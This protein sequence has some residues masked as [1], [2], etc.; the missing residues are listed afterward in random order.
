MIIYILR[1]A[2]CLA[3]LLAVYH[4]LL[5]KKKMHTF[6]RFYLLLSLAAGLILPVLTINISTRTLND[7]PLL[8]K[9]MAVQQTPLLVQPEIPAN[10][11]VEHD[12]L[13]YDPGTLFIIV[14]VLITGVLVAKF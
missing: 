12:A 14:Y 7:T 11:P 4:L 2:I 10:G 3:V 13:P 6:N 1:S 8:S 9:A 5:E